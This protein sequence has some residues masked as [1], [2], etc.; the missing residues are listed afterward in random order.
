MTN[1]RSYTR[2]LPHEVPEGFPIFLTSNLKG[3]MPQAAIEKS[4]KERERLEKQ[5]PHAGELI[6]ARKLR[7]DKLIFAMAD[8]FLDTTTEGPLHLKDLP[9]AKIVEDSILFGAV[10]R[11]ALL[12]W[13][14]MANHVHVLLTPI[15]ELKKIT[16]GLKGFTAYEINSIQDARGRILWQDESYDHWARDEAEMLRIIE[17]IENN[18]VAAR[19]C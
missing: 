2:H 4:L 19:L 11:Y 12:A 10:E 13:C 5:A 8:R 9:A 16:Q 17:Y 18:P 3:A 6:A 15:W 7:E 14:V 1:K